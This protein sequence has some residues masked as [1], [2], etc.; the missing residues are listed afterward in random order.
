M[1]SDIFGL[2]PAMKSIDIG[3]VSRLTN[4]LDGPCMLISP[5]LV[6]RLV[7]GTLAPTDY[8]GSSFG[9]QSPVSQSQSYSIMW[10][11][12][13]L[14]SFRDMPRME[15]W[16]SFKRSNDHSVGYS[17]LCIHDLI[18]RCEQHWKKWFKGD[19]CAFCIF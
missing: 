16:L 1:Y 14:V 13:D 12:S 8:G 3:D 17:M 11:C 18:R 4:P 2:P 5:S 9:L 7:E 15:A 6:R 10:T 19:G